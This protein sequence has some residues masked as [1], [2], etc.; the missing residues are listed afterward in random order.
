MQS[1]LQ[2]LSCLVWRFDFGCVDSDSADLFLLQ[3]CISSLNYCRFVLSLKSQSS[4]LCRAVP[5]LSWLWCPRPSAPFVLH[6]IRRVLAVSTASPF[7]FPAQLYSTFPFK[8]FPFLALTPYSASPN[9]ALSD[10]F[11]NSNNG[12]HRS[13]QAS[14]F[15]MLAAA[16]W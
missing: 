2:T 11:S 16:K 13:N 6:L 3:E 4:T 15:N 7:S 12:L 9:F 5:V 10:Y 8:A 14:T 1:C